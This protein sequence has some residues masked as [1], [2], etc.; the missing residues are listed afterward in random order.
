MYN[1]W[2]EFITYY[3][4]TWFLLIHV[5]CLCIYL[6]M[7]I[8]KFY[9]HISCVYVYVSDRIYPVELRQLVIQKSFKSLI[10]QFWFKFTYRFV[11]EQLQNQSQ[12]YH[13]KTTTFTC[14]YNCTLLSIA[15]NNIMIV[16]KH[17][18]MKSVLSVN[19]FFA[20]KYNQKCVS[21]LN[22]KLYILGHFLMLWL[23]LYEQ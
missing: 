1:L 16:R 14:N 13:K 21:W 6:C 8:F 4:D 17:A 5:L 11:T 3:T 15:H 22:T 10:Y 2:A 7:S 9:I 20:W 19:I 18:T 12:L 23:L